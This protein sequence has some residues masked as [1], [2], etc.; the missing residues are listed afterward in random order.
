METNAGQSVDRQEA[1]SSERDESEQAA[2]RPRLPDSDESRYKIVH[3]DLMAEYFKLIDIVTSFDSRLLTIKGWGVTLSLAS[4]GLGFQQGHYGLFLVA[5]LSGLA[6]WVVE[7]TTKNHQRRYY[8]RMGDIEEAAFRLYLVEKDGGPISSPMI[9]WGWYV[10]MQ[11]FIVGARYKGDPSRPKRWQNDAS[12]GLIDD[13]KAKRDEKG[14]LRIY[15]R[16]TR[17]RELIKRV[18]SSPMLY[19]HVMFPHVIAVIAGITL[20]AIG[21]SGKLGHI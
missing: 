15:S 7:G 13:Q 3:D 16:A 17:A 6:F 14:N 8:P 5:A 2:T 9:D 11:R 19:P 21:L 18:R 20:F 4:L 10:A 1:Y 12:Q